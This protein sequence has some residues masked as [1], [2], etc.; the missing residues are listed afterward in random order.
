MVESPELLTIYGAMPADPAKQQAWFDS[1]DA[2]FPGIKLD[3]VDPE[4][5]ARLPGHPQQ[6]VVRPEL[7]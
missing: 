7:R 5:H 2:N 4:G 6:S 1:I 3:W